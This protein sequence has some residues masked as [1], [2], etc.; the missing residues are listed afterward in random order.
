[1]LPQ[2]NTSWPPKVE[3]GTWWDRLDEWEVWFSGD[4]MSLESFYSSRT[5]ADANTNRFWAG[6]RQEKQRVLHLPAA[7]DVAATSASLLFSE[8]PVVEPAEAGEGAN[9]LEVI[10]EEN[11]FDATVLEAAEMA[12]ALGG[13]YLK[14]DT[15]PQFVP[16]PIVVPIKPASVVP[17]F[18]RGRLW[19]ITFW[20]VIKKDDS[21]WWYFFEERTNPTGEELNIRYKLFRGNEGSIGQEEENLGAI[22]ETQALGLKDTTLPVPGLGVIY[23]PN[24]LPNRLLPG[25]P[26][27]MSDYGSCCTLLDALDEAWT[28]WMRDIRMGLGKLLLDKEFLEDV[29]KSQFGH[30]QE[31]FVMLNLGALR[32][33]ASD[34]YEPVKE[35]QFEIR[36]EAHLATTTALFTE[37]VDRCGYNPQTFGLEIKGTA[38]SGTA[39]R[40]RERKS[41]MT[42]Q[43]KSR[44]W[45]WALK[46]LIL[47]L[48][49]YDVA[50]GT[51]EVKYD[52]S[53]VTVELQDSVTPDAKEVS[54][55]VMNLRNAKVMSQEVSIRMVHPDWDDKQVKKELTRLEGEEPEPI[56]PF[57]PGEEEEGGE[58]NNEGDDT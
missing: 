53:E 28:S 58:E 2:P 48:Q 50:A 22:P 42:R 29:D 56:E 39:L 27:G 15:D 54:E 26:Q 45:Q 33:G 32:L 10:L 9:R 40:I 18:R 57:V 8:K 49:M 3:L 16:T 17:I 7:S 36:H 12:A 34:K 20:R 47:E 4:T 52:P 13:V 25:N 30:F 44:Y 51:S 14:I 35:I 41:M 38:Q 55:T 37:I 19:E 23:V 31:T 11:R 6:V 1:M 21:N 43:K 24:V 46:R 5:Y